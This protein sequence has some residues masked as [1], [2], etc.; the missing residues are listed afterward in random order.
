M[1]YLKA[2]YILSG[3]IGGLPEETDDLCWFYRVFETCRCGYWTEEESRRLRLRVKFSLTYRAV[4]QPVFQPQPPKGLNDATSG[5]L[6]QV[7]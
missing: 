5:G 7:A 3:N 1:I 6:Q 2:L 4:K